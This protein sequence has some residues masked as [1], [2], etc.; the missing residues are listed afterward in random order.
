MR[1]HT[2]TLRRPSVA[3]L[4]EVDLASLLNVRHGRRSQVDEYQ[5]CS[6]ALDF[7]MPCPQPVRPPHH[8][9]VCWNPAINIGWAFVRGSSQ[10]NGKVLK[11]IGASDP[12]PISFEL[13][14]SS[15]DQKTMSSGL[16]SFFLNCPDVFIINVIAPGR[17][18]LALAHHSSFC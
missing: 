7:V 12:Y 2:Q 11:F 14:L 8:I 15:A 10:P 9:A 3:I 18:T 13:R 16:P 17:V 4:P 1:A 5:R 6:P